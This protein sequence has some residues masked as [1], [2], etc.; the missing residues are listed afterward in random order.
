MN[1]EENM[2]KKQN[3]KKNI[4][5]KGSWITLLNKMMWFSVWYVLPSYLVYLFL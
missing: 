3:M 1:W 4:E 5:I 2:G